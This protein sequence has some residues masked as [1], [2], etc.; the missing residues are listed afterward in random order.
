VN[1]LEL[2]NAEAMEK[3]AVALE[4]EYRFDAI[5]IA[6]VVLLSTSKLINRKVEDSGFRTDYGASILGIQRRDEYILQNLRDEKMQAG[7]ALL[8]QGAWGDIRRLSDA[9]H[10][11]VV[12]GQPLTEASKLTLDHKAPWAGGILLLLIAAMVADILPTVTAIML[13][14]VLMIFSG[15]FK[16]MEEAYKT[17]NWESVVLIAAMLPMSVAIEKTGVTALVAKT[18]AG[19]IGSMGPHALLGVIYFATS[20]LTL[21]LS[22]TTTAVLFAPIAFQAASGLGLSPYPFLFGVAVASCMCFASPFSTPP[23]ALVMSPG[24]YTFMDYIRVGVPLQTLFGLV[25]VAL[26]PLIFPFAL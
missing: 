11:W 13:A 14:A 12:V 4:D 23:N 22:N 2:M 17:I 24:R 9:S 7:D 19:D 6:E 10:D 18:L 5:G 8:I 21:F 3:A 16:N 15:C 20:L 1:N 26:L 25:M